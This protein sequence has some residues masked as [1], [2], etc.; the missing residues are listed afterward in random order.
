MNNSLQHHVFACPVDASAAT[1]TLSLADANYLVFS[2]GIALTAMP[3]VNDMRLAGVWNLTGNWNEPPPGASIMSG[4]T[5]NVSGALDSGYNI[6]INANATLNVAEVKAPLGATNKN[7]FLYKN[8]GTFNV[9]GEMLDTIASSASTA[10]SLAGS[11]AKGDSKAVTRTKGLVHSGSTKSNH[12]FILNNTEDSVT[13]TFVL[14]S[15]GLSFRDQL[16]LLSVFPDRFRQ[17]RDARVVRRLV[18]WRESSFGQGLE[19]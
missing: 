15:G 6:V 14:G 5:V 10:Y 9:T 17:G 1:P 4:S 8:A 13:N 18:V 11:F 16:C 3:S 19:P 12:Q 7:R 2:G